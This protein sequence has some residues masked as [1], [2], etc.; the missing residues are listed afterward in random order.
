MSNH[1]PLYVD[2]KAKLCFG[3]RLSHHAALIGGARNEPDPW[4]QETRQ[5]SDRARW[6]RR[7]KQGKER[8]VSCLVCLFWECSLLSGHPRSFPG[9]RWASSACV[10]AR[11]LWQHLTGCHHCFAQCVLAHLTWCLARRRV[12]QRTS[13]PSL[14][15]HIL[16]YLAV[17]RGVSKNIRVVIHQL[18]S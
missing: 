7:P 3:L 15:K 1:Q 16:P 5:K 18:I 13:L 6:D 9:A 14:T 10:A 17:R 2:P 4:Q 12:S 8:P 11:H